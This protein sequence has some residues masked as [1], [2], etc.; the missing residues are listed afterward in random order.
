[1]EELQA[2]KAGRELQRRQSAIQ[3]PEQTERQHL[4]RRVM[5]QRFATDLI[6]KYRLKPGKQVG[7]GGRLVCR[8]S[9][10]RLSLLVDLWT[11]PSSLST[12]V[13][14]NRWLISSGR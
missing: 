10:P 1:M 5:P 13:R 12:P 6:I 2:L 14:V 7:G 3:S 4:Y 8:G 9:P 11:C